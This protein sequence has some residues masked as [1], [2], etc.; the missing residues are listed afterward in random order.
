MLDSLELMR[1]HGGRV[2]R[3][4]G[5]LWVAD[6]AQWRAGQ[7]DAIEDP[8]CR[9]ETL[10]ALYKR[11]LVVWRA[12]DEAVE[13]SAAGRILADAVALVRE[14]F[15]ALDPEQLEQASPDDGPFFKWGGA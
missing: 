1:S 4:E 3:I 8:W 13:L 7:R 10:R 15:A 14:R 12:E 2:Y 9:V 6:P 11:G 5:G